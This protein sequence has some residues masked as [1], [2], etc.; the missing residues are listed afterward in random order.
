MKTQELKASSPLRVRV[1]RAAVLTAAAILPITAT[2]DR[3]PEVPER[4]QVP[5]GHQPAFHVYATGVQIYTVRNTG[6]PET[7]KY[8]WVFIA[9]LAE[10][11]ADGGGNGKV[12]IHYAGPTWESK[13]G[14][15]VVGARVDGVTVDPTAIPWLLLR[16]ASTSGPGIFGGVTYIQRI[17]T[18]GGLAP[19]TGADAAHEGEEARVPYTAEYWFY[20][21][22]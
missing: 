13:S 4:L 6:T 17:N 7:P 1:V 10:L 16:A 11:Y 14:S 3:T 22:R 9:P 20:R 21:E 12:G 5:E 18:A 15:K 8:E 2:A 19:T